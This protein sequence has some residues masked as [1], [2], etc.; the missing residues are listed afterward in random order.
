MIS[1]RLSDSQTVNRQTG[2]ARR[3]VRRPSYCIA[4]LTNDPPLHNIKVIMIMKTIAF[5]TILGFLLT[6]VAGICQA[7]PD[8]TGIWK[9]TSLCQ[10]KNSPCHD[11]EVVYYISKLDSS[12]QCRIIMNKIVNKKEESMGAMKFE[13]DPA[14]QTLTSTDGVHNAQWKFSVNG[15]K[16]DGTLVY[17]NALYRII[18]A[19]K[20]E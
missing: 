6:P 11:E 9:G 7:K 15:K 19:T 17:N 3:G 16:M 14:T 4:S 12:S 13:Y 18:K 20:S 1:D 5:T 2:T 10:V 8:V